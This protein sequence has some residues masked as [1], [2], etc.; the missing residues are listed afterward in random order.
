MPPRRRLQGWI[1]ALALVGAGAGHAAD[2][3]PPPDV[4]DAATLARDMKTEQ[5]ILAAA[6]TG[7][8]DVIGA[9]QADLR[10]I[11]SHAPSPFSP[12]EERGGTVYVRVTSMEGCL[13]AMATYAA[14]KPAAGPMRSA[15]IDNPYPTAALMIGSY[16]DEVHRFEEGLVMLDRGL[17]FDPNYPP[18]VAEKGSAL[19]M[20]HRPAEGL[21]VYQGGLDRIHPLSDRMRGTFLRGEGFALVDLNRLDEAEAA[22]RESLKADPNHGRATQ[23]L[24]FITRTRAGTAPTGPSTTESGIPHAT[25]PK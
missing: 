17:A 13:I 15:C 19:N 4:P 20:L 2:P 16:L 18:L 23:E 10:A 9:R 22:Y 14:K 24:E 12:I 7:G 3:V 21:A 5:D 8:F 1:V 6:Q 25:P 11:L